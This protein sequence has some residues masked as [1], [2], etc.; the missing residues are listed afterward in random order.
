MDKDPYDV[1]CGANHTLVLT[2]YGTVFSWGNNN[3]GQCGVLKSS[4]TNVEVKVNK[5][6][7]ANCCN[8]SQIGISMYILLRNLSGL[9]TQKLGRNEDF[10]L[11]VIHSKYSKSKTSKDWFAT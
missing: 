2:R 8:I 5:P 7:L 3:H 10:L 11:I 9:A 6:T 4:M 1:E